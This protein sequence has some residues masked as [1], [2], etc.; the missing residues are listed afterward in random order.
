MTVERL[1]GDL[2][3]PEVEMWRITLQPGY[4]SGRDRIEYQGE[5]LALGEQGEVTFHVGDEE[6]VL[7]AGDVLHFKAS[8]PHSWRNESEDVARF[9]ILGTVSPALREA[10]HSRLSPPSRRRAAGK[11]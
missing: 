7:R 11:G 2:F 3:D 1:S 10:L 5:E 8:A 6:Y 4:G 9:V